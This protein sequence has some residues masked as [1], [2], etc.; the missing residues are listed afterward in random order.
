[1]AYQWYSIIGVDYLFSSFPIF[2]GSSVYGERINLKASALNC[3][4]C[5]CVGLCVPLIKPSTACCSR[6]TEKTKTK[7]GSV[8]LR[9]VWSHLIFQ[10]LWHFHLLHLKLKNACKHWKRAIF[11]YYNVF[12]LCFSICACICF[13]SKCAYNKLIYLYSF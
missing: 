5:T 4:F 12:I 1:M 10:L 7:C 11:M 9:N 8:G 13:Y 6:H 2:S 3:S